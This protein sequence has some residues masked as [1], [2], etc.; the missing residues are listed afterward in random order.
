MN[1]MELRRKLVVSARR[2]VIKMGSGLLSRAEGLDT[3]RMGRLAT[4]ISQIKEQGREVVLVSSGAIASGFKKMGL[5]EKPRTVRQQQA[6]AAVGQPGLMIIWE[7]C[8]ERR[9]HKVAQVL[10]TADDLSHRRRYLNSRNTLTTLL[11]WKVIP[12]INENDTVVVAEIKYGDNDTLAG[13][14]AS[15][16]EADLFINLTDIDGLFDRDPRGDCQ[17]CFIPVVETV[18]PRIEA[19]AGRIPGA[20]GSGGMYTKIVAARRLARLGVPSIIANGARKDTLMRIMAGEVEGTLFLP[21]EKTLRSRKH[22]LAFTAKTRGRIVVDDGARR[23]LID[24]GKSLLPSGLVEVQENFSS[25]DPIKVLD[26]AGQVI[27]V[28]LTNYSSEELRLIAGCHTSDIEARLGYKH[29][30]E[31]I[32]RDNLVAGD[33]L[34]A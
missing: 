27:A 8:F 18:G 16:I 3:R 26:T 30:D 7:E 25:G 31:V 4:Q 1:D 34:T 15:L 17:A 32:H 13:L 10:L 12:I 5:A 29:S 2:L 14:V 21:R 33:D 19:M 28:G 20:L 9:G 24:N 23:A 6:C 11:E 22:W